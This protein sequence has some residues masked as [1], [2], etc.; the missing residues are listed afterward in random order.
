MNIQIPSDM[1][2][3]STFTCGPSQGHPEIRN[4]KLSDTLYERSHR[5]GDIT[6]AGLIKEATEGLRELMGIPKDYAIIFY[7]GGATPALDATAWGL[8]TDSISGLRFGTFSQLWGKKIASAL[9]DS[10]K[11]EFID[12]DKDGTLPEKEPNCNASLVLLTPNE[13]SMGVQIPN[14]YLED[15]WNKK[16]KDTLIAWDCTSCAG[17]RDLPQDKY[18]ALVFSMQKCFGAPGGS[19]VLVLSPKAIERVMKV[20]QMRKI[21]FSLDLQEPIKRATEK[22]QTLNTPSTTNIWIFNESVKWMNK[23]GGIK[24][25]DKLSRQHA[26]YLLNFAKKTDYL[27]P[28]VEKEEHRSYVTLTLKIT[29]SKIKDIDINE[30]LNKTGKDNLKDGIKKYSSIKEN[31]LRIACFPFVDIN[32]VGEYEKLTQCIDYIAKELRKG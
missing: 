28:F 12:S 8:T 23:F 22:Y 29:D 7:H 27:A 13:T 5:A 19:S 17:G 2:P 18:D 10:I 11:K 14:D 1:L 15:A 32:G 6:K 3:N 31:S 24:A 20:K 4:A 30:A 21:P 16:G 25:I 9:D 26:D